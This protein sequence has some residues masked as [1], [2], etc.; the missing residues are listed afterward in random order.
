M[1]LR[2]AL[3]DLGEDLNRFT[4]VLLV[5]LAAGVLLAIVWWGAA[6]A[7]ASAQTKGFLPLLQDQAVSAITLAIIGLA[8]WLGF[9]LRFR[10]AKSRYLRPYRRAVGAAPDP[11]LREILDHLTAVRPRRSLLVI[12]ESDRF[13]ELTGDLPRLLARRGLVP[14]VVDM[15][16]VDSPVRVPARSREA[17]VARLASATGDEARAQRVFTREADRGKIVVLVAGLDLVAEAKPRAARRAIIEELL[18]SCVEERLPFVA[19]VSDELAPRI[20]E[21]ASVR[22][23]RTYELPA[24][25]EDF[26]AR[27]VDRG[28][29]YDPAVEAAVRYAFALRDP[30]TD[31]WYL[32]RAADAV[33]MRMRAG[34]EPDRAVRDLFAEPRSFVRHLGWLRETAL[35]PDPDADSAVAR[36]LSALGRLAHHRQEVTIR[37]RDA[38][39]QLP[40]GDELA[41]AAAVSTLTRR[42]VIILAGDMSDPELRFAHLDYLA[43]AGALGLG[44]DP[45]AWADLLTVGVPTTT[46]RALTAALLL[47]P[48]G[49][50]EAS[51]LA[52][53]S[54]LKRG[55]TRDMSLDMITAVVLAL[56]QSGVRPAFGEPEIAA[57][58]RAWRAATDQSRLLFVAETDHQA[59]LVRYLWRQVVPPRFHVNSYRLRR[60]ICA[61][62]ARMGA[63]AWRQ[64]ADPWREL[65]AG[66]DG[67]DLSALARLTRTDWVRVALPLASA[68]WILPS[69]ADRLSG[70]EQRECVALIGRVR[71]LFTAGDH[72]DP[73]L[74]ISLAEGVKFAA[75]ARGFAARGIEPAWLDEAKQLLAVVRSWTSEQVLC[76]A[77]A[78][79]TADGFTFAARHAAKGA[80]PFVREAVALAQRARRAAIDASPGAGTSR[81]WIITRDIWFDDVAALED[82]GFHLS[83]EAH[84]LLALSTLL[85]DLAEGS[86]DA[87][88]REHAAAGAPAGV[89]AAV[90]RGVA[91]RERAFTSTDLPRCLVS[92]THAATMLDVD[93]DCAFDLCGRRMAGP[94]GLRHIS[95]AFA[96]RAEVTAGRR[97]AQRGR[98]PFARRAL[99]HLWQR[100]DN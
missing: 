38:A 4:S 32:E 15:S 96:R 46:A 83:P 24:L 75:V 77:M 95:K 54:R 97:P 12:A 36:S 57:L 92:S 86:H 23:S 94:L 44:L 62:L 42:G 58:D 61:R 63:V 28:V 26:R 17:F 81:E 5:G 55:E 19:A 49:V 11:L 34:A 85:I 67:A 39:A 71:T 53:L 68:S 64:L 10:D 79:A 6:S 13:P 1:R 76:Q 74:E 8:A 99:A 69:L 25:R 90:A 33:L 9:R 88:A 72:V 35:G 80:H 60:A 7:Q 37:W 14:V 43:L 84:R 56:R 78:L 27:L 51:F 87:A 70:D 29:P 31:P 30:S 16:D 20:S 98:R 82:G 3:T 45:H 47:H 73:G 100:W 65:V 2:T 91:A 21:V 52:V 22:V 40:P 89:S 59:E 50:A 48:D 66:G 93:C 18:R 41:F